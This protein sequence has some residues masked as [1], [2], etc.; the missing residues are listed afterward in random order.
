MS[1]L[2]ILKLDI[3]KHNVFKI[4]RC[5]GQYACDLEVSDCSPHEVESAVWMKKRFLS[6]QVKSSGNGLD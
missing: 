6:G 5:S 2:M 1:E 4:M 3:N